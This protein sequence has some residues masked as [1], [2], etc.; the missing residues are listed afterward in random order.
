MRT[1]PNPLPF[2]HP[3]KV[4]KKERTFIMDKKTI[5]KDGNVRLTKKKDFFTKK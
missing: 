2:M 5:K 1:A 4:K 3:N